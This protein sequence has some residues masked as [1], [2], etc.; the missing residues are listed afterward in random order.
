MAQLKIITEIEATISALA[1]LIESLGNA[2]LYK[3]LRDPLGFA[4]VWCDDLKTEQITFKDPD[5]ISKQLE[6]SIKDSIGLINQAVIEAPYQQQVG[7]LVEKLQ[8]LTAEYISSLDAAAK[9][10]AN[11]SDSRALTKGL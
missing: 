7:S 2:E 1:D 6:K 10:E 5:A 9:S 4:L 3:S 8:Q 11:D